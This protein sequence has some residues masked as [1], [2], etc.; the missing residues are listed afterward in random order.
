MVAQK[1]EHRVLL[2]KTDLLFLLIILGLWRYRREPV[3]K[4]L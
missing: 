1:L 3:V 2:I 4:K